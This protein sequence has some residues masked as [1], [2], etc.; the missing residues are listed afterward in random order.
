MRIAFFGGSFDPPH[1]GHLA[2]ARAARKA[3]ALDEVW[4]AP[5]GAQPL[6]SAATASYADR[7]AMTRLAIRNS[8]GF[9]LSTLDAP[10]P[11]SKPNYTADTLVRMRESLRK[12]DKLFLLIGADSLLTLPQWHR[13]EEIPFLAQ[14]IV[15]AR[16]GFA[17][18]N[19]AESLPPGLA[20]DSAEQKSPGLMTFVLSG[21]GGQRTKLSL[22]PDMDEDISA[23]E[24]RAALATGINAAHLL[25]AEVF[26]Y[27]QRN[28]LYQSNSLATGASKRYD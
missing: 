9:R 12:P 7:C 20:L 1:R 26:R 21:P 24:I 17:L 14:I 8:R 16:P 4:F 19:L 22:L 25:G 5:V 28:H 13:P 2:I 18:R 10:Q 3:L 27:I 6:R 11:D 23:T 15:A